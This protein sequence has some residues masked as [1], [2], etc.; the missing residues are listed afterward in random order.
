MQPMTIEQRRIA[1]A[2]LVGVA[3][4]LGALV[5]KNFGGGGSQYPTTAAV[6][7]KTMPTTIPE[8]D[9]ITVT[10]SNGDGVE[11]WREEFVMQ[12]PIELPAGTSS[13]AFTMPTTVTDQVGIQLFET[14]I[15]SKANNIP[16]QSNEDIAIRTAGKIQGLAQDTLYTTSDVTVISTDPVSIRRYGNTMGQ[17]MINHNVKSEGELEIMYQAV[18]TND[19][20]AIKKLEPLA[21][22]YK[23][24]RDDALATPVPDRF[25]AEHVLLIN[26]YHAMYRNLS[27]FQLVFDDPIVALLRIKRYQDD[28]TALGIALNRMYRN[29]APFA[30]LF[31]EDDPA[32]IFTA[33]S[34]NI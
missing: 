16:T 25:V 21:E 32:M 34:N 14:L 29:A 33:F 8:R 26:A 13:V 11:D 2:S 27:D 23:K 3:L 28:A 15:R 12:A 19:A 22:M 10:D 20:E 18:Q 4:I 7:T 9:F 6:T 30:T 31:R 17:S 1:G 5:I 24:L